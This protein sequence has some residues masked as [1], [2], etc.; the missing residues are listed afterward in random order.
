MNAAIME[1]ICFA[2]PNGRKFEI[3]MDDA[4]VLHCYVAGRANGR[5]LVTPSSNTSIEISSSRLPKPT[6]D[7]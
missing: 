2:H 7:K 1:T 4:G 5:L 3:H 6:K